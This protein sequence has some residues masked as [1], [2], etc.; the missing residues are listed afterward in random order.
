MKPKKINSVLDLTRKIT[1]QG[2]VYNPLFAGAPGIGK[3]QIV[4][5]WCRKN[6]IPFVDLRAAYLEAPDLIGFPSITTDE[7]G[8]SVTSHNLP[9][10]WPHKGEY[11]I[12]LDE[13]NRGNT[14]VLNCFMQVLT[15]RKI[16]KYTLPPEAMVVSAINPE[17][18]MYDVT[19]MDP[20]LKNRYVI[21]D[22]QYDKR[23]FVD[24]MRSA[25]WNEHLI[26]FVDSGGWEY[27]LPEDVGKAA[28]N[29]YLSPRSFAQANAVLNAGLGLAEGLTKAQRNEEEETESEALESILGRNVA[30]AFDQFRKK[31]QPVLM[32]DLLHNKKEALAKLK[33]YSDPKSYKYG[34]IA[35]TVKSIVTDNS[36]DNALLS[37]VLMVVPA[38]VATALVRELQDKR[39]DKTLFRTLCDN[40]KALKKHLKENLK[41][42]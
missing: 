37:E 21:Y 27:K 22:V 30:K 6:N 16:H 8:R 26:M 38:D 18:Q 32:S 10:F 23:S 29:K 25:K 2:E 36:I 40:D 39:G 7:H 9:E 31:E 3:S 24:Y 13:P 12:F 19:T 14:G 20:A 28:G 5:E 42:D 4:Q 17:G 1:K 34:H 15:D 11:V 33:V 35:I 41:V